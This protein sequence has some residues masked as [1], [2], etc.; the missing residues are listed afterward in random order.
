[1]NNCINNKHI[2]SHCAIIT[3][4]YVLFERFFMPIEPDELRA[5]LLALKKQY[6]GIHWLGSNKEKLNNFVKR[7]EQIPAAIR[8]YND[9]KEAARLLTGTLAKIAEKAVRA[10][11][12]KKLDS[13]EIEQTRAAT[14]EVHTKAIKEKDAAYLAESYPDT[15]LRDLENEFK[16]RALEYYAKNHKKSPPPKDEKLAIQEFIQMLNREQNKHAF[17]RGIGLILEKHYE[18]SNNMTYDDLQRPEEA[19]LSS[20]SDV[21]IHLATPADRPAVEGDDSP[22]AGRPTVEVKDSAP[23][24]RS[25]VECDNP[26]PT[27]R[28]SGEGNDSPPAPVNVHL[29]GDGKDDRAPGERKHSFSGS[30]GRSK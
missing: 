8:R 12:D 11:N 19:R 28:S 16:K 29:A 13:A 22:P 26:V 14:L 3:Y 5:D 15:I 20:Y 17:Y 21:M 25:A 30:P 6:K 10:E 1:M 9:A 23:A 18:D 7:A 2:L 24:S 27:S 4:N